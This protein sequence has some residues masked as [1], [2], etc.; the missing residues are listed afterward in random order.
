VP[1]KKGA[2]KTAALFQDELMY[3]R[4]EHS[5]DDY[6]CSLALGDSLHLHLAKLNMFVFKCYGL[7]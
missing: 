2:G 7:V 3:P 6:Y 1:A 4:A 5:E